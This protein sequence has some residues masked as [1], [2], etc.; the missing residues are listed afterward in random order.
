MYIGRL[1][2]EL[3]SAA[4]ILRVIDAGVGILMALAFGAMPK[5]QQERN[6]MG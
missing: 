1:H 3:F 4:L 2:A 6:G 5:T